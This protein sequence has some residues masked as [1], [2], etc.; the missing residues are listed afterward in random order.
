MKLATI[1]VIAGGA[2]AVYLAYKAFTATATTQPGTQATNKC[3]SQNVSSASCLLSSIESG[4]SGL[5]QYM[6]SAAG[7]IAAVPLSC[8]STPGSAQN[9]ECSNA[10]QTATKNPYGAGTS[11]TYACAADNP[12]CPSVQASTNLTQ[13]S[14]CTTYACSLV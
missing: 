13:P 3:G 5:T 8:M 9:T 6:T 12:T 2:A 4:V 14:D 1:A 10:I 7:T 11:T